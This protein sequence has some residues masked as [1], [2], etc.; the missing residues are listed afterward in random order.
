MDE[1]LLQKIQEL[2]ALHFGVRVEDLSSQSRLQGISDARTAFIHAVY[3]VKTSKGHPYIGGVRLA[4]IVHCSSA[5][6]YFHLQKY[7]AIRQQKLFRTVLDEFEQDVHNA[8]EEWR[9]KKLSK[10]GLT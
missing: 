7:E 2:T 10:L 1:A 5:A 9:S 3:N 4:Q 8:V 6:I